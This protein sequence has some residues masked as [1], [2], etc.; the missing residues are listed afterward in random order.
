M[1]V[2]LSLLKLLLGIFENTKAEGT[3][4]SEVGPVL[5]SHSDFC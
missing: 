1:E 4:A 3:S 2:A 5:A